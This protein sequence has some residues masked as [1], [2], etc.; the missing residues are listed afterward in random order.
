MDVSDH[1]SN[2]PEPEE[3]DP[4]DNLSKSMIAKVPEKDPP[5]R[6]ATLV[7][8]QTQEEVQHVPPTQK[9]LVAEDS[10]L[11]TEEVQHVPPTQ[12]VLVAADSALQ[13]KKSSMFLLH[14]KSW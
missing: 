12:Q 11:A 10:A 5:D 9:V 2:N 6:L 3:P 13:Q 1:H 8:C 4:T 7:V 14:R